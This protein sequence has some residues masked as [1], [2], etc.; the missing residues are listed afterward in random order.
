MN[1]ERNMIISSCLFIISIVIMG[2]A[3]GMEENKSNI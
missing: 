2:I 3:I 1:V